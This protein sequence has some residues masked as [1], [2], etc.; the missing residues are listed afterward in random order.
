MIGEETVEYGGKRL[1]IKHITNHYYIPLILSNDEKIDYIKHI[2]KTSSEIRFINDLEGYLKGNN[3]FSEFD[4]WLFSKLD[5]SLDEVYI[6]YYNPK[7]NGISQFK[8]DFVFW[9]QRGD[10]YFIA[11]VD[12][13]GI[14]YTDY[15]HKIDG[16]RGIFE[17]DGNGK[18]ILSHEGLKARVFTFLYTD[19]VNELSEGYREYWF[20][21][22]DAALG[23]MLDL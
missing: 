19:D 13:K 18:K 3:R 10:D 12:P 16:Y 22:I 5:E 14:E 1:R 8:P 2:I 11:F 4:W 21:S 20:D 15:E 17:E 23:S 9:L 7:T 6:P